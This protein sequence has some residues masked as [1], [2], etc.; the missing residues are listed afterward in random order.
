MNNSIEAK[1]RAFVCRNARPLDWAR[2]QYHFEAGAQQAVLT[3][4][5]A[6]QNL[7]GGFAHALEPDAWNPHSTPIQTWAATETLWEIGFDD[8]RHP[9]VQGILRYLGSGQDFDGRTWANAPDSNNG[10]PHAPWWH[11]ESVSTSHHGYNPTAA[12]SGFI[13]RFADRDSAL[14]SLGCRIAR[15]AVDVYLLEGLLTDMHTAACYLRLWQYVGQAGIAGEIDLHQLK[16]QLDRQVAHSITR[17]TAQWE[18]GY[19]C[20]P[21]QFFTDCGSPF[22]PGNEAIAAHECDFIIKS[23]L[24]D[25]SF[26]IPWGWN[27]FPEEWAVSKN[28]WKGIVT[29]NNLRFLKGMGRL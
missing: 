6:Y 8:A 29:V 11:S 21:S 16:A 23:Q 5:S 20:K 1:A 3:A 24:P 27:A 12:L 10:Y 25:G 9:I 14:Y 7:D 17:D 18:T 13:L 22:Y 4:L 26:A 2:W 15:E 28:W 19:I